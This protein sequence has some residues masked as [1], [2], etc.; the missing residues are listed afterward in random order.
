ESD[1][2]YYAAYGILDEELTYDPAELPE[3]DL[4]QRAFEIVMARQV[5]AGELDNEWFDRHG[6]VPIT[7]VPKHWP[8]GY[9][10]SVRRRIDIIE[11]NR[12]IGLLERPEYK[13]RW[14]EESW[15]ERQERALRNWLLERIESRDQWFDKQGRPSVSSVGQ[16][17]DSLG[18][19]SEFMSVLD[20]WTGQRDADP[21]ANLTKLLEIEAVPYLAAWRLKPS[22]LRKFEDWKVTWDLQRREDAGETVGSIPVP[23]K[24][25]TANF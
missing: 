23:S 3:V 17:A 21:V 14:S 11:D 7:A 1:W 24:Y 12:M 15:E 25:T 20:L 16:L 4:G 2:H 19:D 8:E 6:S 5:E 22:G 10:E 13:R 9:Q 18:R